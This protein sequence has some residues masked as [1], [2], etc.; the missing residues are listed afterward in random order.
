MRVPLGTADHPEWK[1]WERVFEQIP[2]PLAA[3]DLDGHIIYINPAAKKL[4]GF[5]ADQLIGA[6]ARQFIHP[7]DSPAQIDNLIAHGI[8]H[9][10]AD[11]R[12]Q[13]PN[14]RTYWVSLSAA[15]IT[16][17]DHLPFFFL[18]QFQDVTKQHRA[19]T[20]WKATVD[21]APIGMALVNLQGLWLDVNDR[22]C[23]I[24]GYSRE[25]LTALHTADLTYGDG[26][27]DMREVLTTLAA[28]GEQQVTTLK[29]RYRHKDGY[30]L[31]VLVRISVVPDPD[32]RPAY[33]VSQYETLGDEAKQ[34]R[35][36]AHMAL[37]DPLTGL[38]NRVLF[39]DNARRELADL[40]TSTHLLTMLLI[41][42]D[43]LKPINDSYGHV[44]GDRILTS[45]AH[46]L[47]TAVSQGD[48]VA[49]LGGDEF[50]ILSRT[51]NG[52]SARNLRLHIAKKLE[53]KVVA[54]GN[55]I[56]ISASVGL[57]TTQSPRATIAKLLHR[58]DCDMYKHK[59]HK[60]R[61]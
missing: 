43:N 60:Q 40:A 34:D 31:W 10:H 49:R 33:F 19:E 21:H 58:A 20:L 26:D 2:G 46:E 22:L 30:P 41:D 4:S 51:E 7:D 50:V 36:I 5:T 12:I 17:A 39:H 14:G 8:D 1:G 29:E 38:A 27:P 28:G 44:V 55:R 6:P 59:K 54:F 16:D 18:L 53:T 47:L 9:F 15:L 45:V 57:A 13:S 35:N 56:S 25:E 3:L 24:L 42:L 37:H 32:N 48:T 52:P 23:D 11:K 61:T